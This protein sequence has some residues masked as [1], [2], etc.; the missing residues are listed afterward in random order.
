MLAL[1][2][3]ARHVH[4]DP[5]E[6]AVALTLCTTLTPTP[7]SNAIFR[8]PL[9]PRSR[10]AR[11]ASSTSAPTV[12]RPNRLPFAF[13]L[14]S[15]AVTRSRII[16]RSNS[17]NT[18]HI[19]NMAFPAGVVVSMPCW[20]RHR[21]IPTAWISP[22]NVSR[23]WRERPRRSTDQAATISNLRRFASFRRLSR[24]GRASR[25]FAPLTA[26]SS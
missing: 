16:A 2:D 19:W 8:I 13:A 15:P 14:A 23:S 12:G 18:P 9:F 7:I 21:S 4:T 3:E 22:R 1:G 25:P 6:V 11:I 5:I 17:A 24:P 26:K 10:A 20:C